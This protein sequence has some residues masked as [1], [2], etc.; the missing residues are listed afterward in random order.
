LCLRNPSGRVSISPGTD[1]N[2]A[3]TVFQLNSVAATA[4]GKNT[5]R[6]FATEAALDV[7]LAIPANVSLLKP[8]DT[9]LIIDVEVPDYWWDGTQK[10]LL[11]TQ[12]ID[13]TEY[14]RTED[15][16]IQLAGKAT[17]PEISSNGVPF[18]TGGSTGE[19]NIGVAVATSEVGDSIVRRDAEGRARVQE[20]IIDKEIANKI[21]VDT[22]INTLRA[23]IEALEAAI[24]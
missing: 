8:G 4:A 1:N 20:P 13:L 16:D 2:D 24:L 7:W 19:P 17:K 11:E 18:R 9:F 10:Q 21:Y 12:K 14:A 5:N 6:V 22:E 23:R 3:V 15:V